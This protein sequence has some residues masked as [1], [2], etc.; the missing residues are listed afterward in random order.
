MPWVLHMPKFLNM[1]KF[2]IWKSSQYA[3]VTQRSEYAG[4][5][6]DRVMNTSW[7]LNIPAF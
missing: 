3:N 5:C 4:I 1:A 2:T 7:A 6:L